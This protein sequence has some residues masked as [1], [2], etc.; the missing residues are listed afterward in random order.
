ME[1]VG[2]LTPDICYYGKILY[3]CT[4]ENRSKDEDRDYYL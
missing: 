1:K 2:F 4:Y 3:I